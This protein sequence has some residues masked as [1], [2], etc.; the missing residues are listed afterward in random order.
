MTKEQERAI[1]KLTNG[2]KIDFATL[3]RKFKREGIENFVVTKKEYIET[4]LNMIKDLQRENIQ[5]DKQIDLML[6]KINNNYFNIFSGNENNEI[7]NI[8]EKN[9]D[10]S[11][12]IGR[13]LRKACIKQYFERKVKND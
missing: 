4:V 1:G 8:Y 2:E 10:T 11:K 6:E 12:L 7:R 9:K 3:V 5:K 13:S